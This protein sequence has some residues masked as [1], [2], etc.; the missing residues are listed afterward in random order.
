MEDE[1]RR[2]AVRREV[3]QKVLPELVQEGSQLIQSSV[4]TVTTALS[5]F[6]LTLVLSGFMLAES[7]RFREKFHQAFGGDHPLLGSLEGI[8]RDVR[9]YVVAKTWI[10][11]L[12]GTSVWL[13]LE[14]FGVDFAPLWGLL[15]F[16]LNFIPTVGAIVASI[17]PVLVALIDP[18]ISGFALTGI[19][20]GLLTINGTIG[21]VLDPRYVGQAVRVSP[22]VIFSSMLIW[23]VLWGPTGMILAVPIMVSLKVVCSRVPS[24]EPFATMLRG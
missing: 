24:L 17:P 2:K 23:G 11:A 12:T 8:G 13:F 16:P 19:I 7:R 1:N 15:A 3:V 22:L 14:L 9:R 4:G 5:S 21:A 18:S 10:S 20:L 6:F